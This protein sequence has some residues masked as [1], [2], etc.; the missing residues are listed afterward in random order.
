MATSF[1]NNSLAAFDEATGL[2]LSPPSLGAVPLQT[3]FGNVPEADTDAPTG[4]R[5][6]E[7]SV[8]FASRPTR[9]LSA[10]AAFYLQA[11]ITVAFLAGSSAPS[12]LYPVYQAAWGF[13]SLAIT[14]IFGVYAFAVLVALL[15]AGRVS[16]HIGRR[17]VL[18][19]A[20]LVQAATMIVFATAGGLSDLLVAR[21]I[22]GLSAGAAIA[23][24]GAGLLDID[25]SR[26]TI[27][28]SIVAPLGTAAGGLIAGVFVQYLPAPTHLVYLALGVVFILQ[29]VGVYFMNE[30]LTPRPGALASLKPQVRVPVHVRKALL[31]ALPALIATW[32]LAG[33]YAALAPSLV[34]TVFGFGSSLSAGLALFAMAGSAGLAVLVLRNHEAKTV[35]LYGAMALLIGMAITVTALTSLSAPTFYFG[36][37][38]AGIGFGAGF[39]G[40]VRSVVSLAKP[41]ERA[42]VL[43]V[44]FVV[45]YVAMGL[46]AIVAGLFI[47]SH[48]DLRFTT[49]QFAAVVIALAGL[50]LLA[51]LKKSAAHH[52]VVRADG[53]SVVRGDGGSKL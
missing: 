1:I 9:R 8:A 2:R 30:T 6:A 37:A 20:T 36:T 18:L 49:E 32:A 14:V 35:A 27:A 21:V 10:N 50:A 44:I 24:V 45:S 19:V 48:G 42:G 39:Q 33:F 7:T 13:S 22:Q 47:G 43:S 34:R 29:G 53:G 5:R 3:T 12:P 51:A 23:A 40:A 41:D 28:N 52:G 46:P 38:V 16:D 17:P 31:L 15:V 4:A 26:G 25:R 11:S